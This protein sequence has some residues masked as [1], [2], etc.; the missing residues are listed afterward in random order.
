MS[1]KLNVE[2][3]EHAMEL[4]KGKHVVADDGVA[5]HEHR[6]S[7]EKEDQFIRQHGIAEYA[8][9][10]LGIDDREAVES[11]ARY[12]FPYGDF[13]NVHRCG[14]VAVENKAC[15]SEYY[16]IELAASELHGMID[17]KKM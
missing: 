12:K 3:F 8:K 4:L 2:A 11:K 10:Y 13:K 17:A 7:A 5:W 9:W 14:I 6:P 15:E 16:A 1:V